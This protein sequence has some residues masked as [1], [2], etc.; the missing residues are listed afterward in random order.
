MGQRTLGSPHI[1]ECKS[2]RVG[3]CPSH[4]S[5]HWSVVLKKG[6][7]ERARYWRGLNRGIDYQG[8]IKEIP[9]KSIAAYC[10]EVGRVSMV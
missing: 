8:L 6:E 3:S 5:T 2:Q 4:M 1:T 7:S 9:S 10:S